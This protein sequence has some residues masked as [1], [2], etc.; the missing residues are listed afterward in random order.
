V[1]RRPLLP[2]LAEPVGG[3]ID[4]ETPLLPPDT[5]LVAAL[6]ALAAARASAAIAVDA[7]GRGV[8]ILTEQDIARRVAF[9][10]PPDAPLSAAISTPLIAVHADDHLYRAIGL[11][12]LKHLRHL[13]VVDPAGRPV[14]VLHRDQT[15]AALSP[16]IAQLDAL[17]AQDTPDAVHAAKAAQADLA[18]AMLDDGVPALA[19]VALVNA[20]NHD[21][22]RQ[23]TEATLSA[24]PQ[25]PPVPFTLLLM[26]SAG[27]G[28]SLLAPDQDNG[29]IVGD[30]DDADHAAIDAWFRAFAAELTRRLDAAGFTLC[31]G[32]VMATNP[33]WRKRAAEWAHQFALWADRRSPAALLH[34]AIAF[35]LAAAW[36]DAAPV[37]RLRAQLAHIVRA[38]PALLAAMAASDAALSVGLTFWGG[39]ADDE[40]GPGT[41]TDL[42]LHGLMPLVATI[43]LLAVGDGLAETG[44]AAR[45]AALADRGR[46]TGI[47]AEALGA[48][49]ARLTEAILRQQLADRAADRAP[50]SLVDTA[51]LDRES[52]DALR[53]ALRVVRD[54]ARVVRSDL[55]GP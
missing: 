45:I 48:A 5:P 24:Q 52:R 41:R 1:T 20:I 22:H 33:L 47:D 37:A 40:P 54:F 43:R 51:A 23:V 4:R 8:G 14:G 6:A 53:Q 50:G 46:L 27:R 15:L 19:A 18:R 26:G 7:D 16:V 55:A 2:R 17:A 10:L 30:H 49:H 13:A 44:T 9:R 12:R 35:D 36:G 28:E 3:A 21:L 38:R 31:A 11:M 34:A 42:K 39:F 25:K 32:H 29:L